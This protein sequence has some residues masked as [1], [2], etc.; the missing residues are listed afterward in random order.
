LHLCNGSFKLNKRSYMMG[1]ELSLVIML[2]LLLE[3]FREKLQHSWNYNLQLWFYFRK[4]DHNDLTMKQWN[5]LLKIFSSHMISFV[6]FRTAVVPFKCIQ[7]IQFNLDLLHLPE[8]TFD[9]KRISSNSSPK[10]KN[11]VDDYRPRINA[12]LHSRLICSGNPLVYLNSGLNILQYWLNELFCVY[13]V[14]VC[15]CVN[16]WFVASNIHSN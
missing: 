6:K 3:I 16:K 13:C 9:R 15:V 4:I 7:R 5:H 1:K 12:V 2:N 11:I 10:P 8:N 14:C